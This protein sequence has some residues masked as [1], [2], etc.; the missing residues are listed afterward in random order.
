MTA[1]KH[2]HIRC[3]AW[4]ALRHAAAALRHVHHEQAIMW[5]L[6]RQ[7][8]RVSVP[9]TGPLR[10]VL[11]LNGHRLAGGHLAA[12]HRDADRGAA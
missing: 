2:P 12:P 10:W 6:W 1:S 8:N 11:T 5:E 7:A 4:R 9:T 3:A